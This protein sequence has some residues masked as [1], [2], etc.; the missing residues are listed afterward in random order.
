MDNK[1]TLLSEMHLGTM[2]V[3]P[4]N[5]LS[6][7]LLRDY[8]ERYAHSSL[9][10]TKTIQKPSCLPYQSFL[11]HVFHQI[12]HEHSHQSHPLLL[13]NA[14]QRHLWRQILT[15]QTQY[16][17]NEGLLNEIQDAWKRCQYWQLAFDDPAFL[18]TPQ[19]RQFQQWADMF[20]HAL[21][22]CGAI[23]DDQLVN[24]IVTFN[25]VLPRHST[26][27]WACFDDYTPQ[28]H[29]LQQTFQDHGFQQHHYDIAPN[30]PG[31][32][33]YPANDRQDEYQ[34]MITWIQSR[35]AAGD[36]RIAV[37]VPDL[38]TEGAALQRLLQRQLPHDQFN[39]SLGKTLLDFPIIAHAIHWLNL[40]NEI[41]TNHQARLLLHSPYLIGSKTECLARSDIMQHS[42]LL[43]ESF[44]PVDLFTQ[45][46]QTK[47]PK[48][49]TALGQLTHYPPKASAMTWI[50]HFKQRLST[51]GFPGEY[52]LNSASYQ[53]FQRL[54]ALFDEFMQ[55]AA[56]TP[57][58]GKKQA[59]NALHDLAKSTVFQLKQPTTPILVLGLLEASGCSFDS[60]WISGLTDQCLP[61]KTNLSA[62]IPLDLQR[63]RRMPHASADRELQLA[64]QQL[65]RLKNA[66][67]SIVFSYPQFI[68]DMPNLPSA[69]IADLPVLAALATTQALSPPSLVSYEESYCLP[70]LANEQVT[71]GTSLLANQAKCPFRAFA[72]HRL[73]VNPP[74]EVSEGPDA[75]ERGQIIHRIM[76]LLW[77]Q[78]NSQ[79]RLCNMS[80]QAL[81][82]LIED[83]IVTSLKPL[84]QTR[85]FS[86]STIAQDVELIRL[87]RLIHAALDWEKQRPA[88]VVEA[89]EQTFTIRLADIDFQ[90]R[91]DRLDS[92]LTADS[93]SCPQ[94]MVIDYK[95]SIPSKPW[96]EDRPE[97]PQLL[98]YALLDNSI[99]ALLF[100]QLK[101]GRITCSGLSE[102]SLP[103]KGI[104]ALKKDEQWSYYQQ[105][106][107]QQLTDLAYEFQTGASAPRPS[108]ISTCSQCSFHSLCRID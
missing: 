4:N 30:E 47:A 87:K 13:S 6:N 94:K 33:Q 38:Q 36:Q 73:Y 49:I 50:T 5:R 62:F 16:P 41:V 24:Y 81:D 23:T 78:L 101:S 93:D 65:N 22:E 88:F 82:Q 102:Q 85:R 72:A 80:P 107:H 15:A 34:N 29:H 19:T 18:Q 97:S 3:T 7:Q 75:G 89:I 58:M 25:A 52:P 99:N 28:Q 37:V 45:T 67:Q 42:N 32:H 79:D 11:R 60:I 43:K 95:S 35:L 26:I 69:L 91:V 98:L 83:I 64:E 12:R 90:V 63:D 51:L 70:L 20:Q 44:I 10:D 57:I 27:V 14:Q 108:K 55:F 59:I 66:C 105:Q 68:G 21:T 96:N 40:D 77:K 48:L 31:I 74:T 8:Y 76:E 92:L 2:I 100:V 61:Q 39:V 56:V 106:W 53:C 17:C 104:Q 9:T 103:M 86:F 1:N 71:G 54:L 46:C 84:T